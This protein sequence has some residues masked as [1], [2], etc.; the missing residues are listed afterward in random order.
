VVTFYDLDLWIK[1]T[2]AHGLPN[3][4]EEGRNLCPKPCLKVRRESQQDIDVSN[5]PLQR[6]L[7][8][9]LKGHTLAFQ[10]DFNG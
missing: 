2:L 6:A 5:P 1:K 4:S 3:Q 9:R 10:K 8:A 7:K